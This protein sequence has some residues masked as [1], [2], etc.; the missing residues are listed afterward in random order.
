M[1][2]SA[3]ARHRRLASTTASRR[4]SAGCCTTPSRCWPTSSTPCD[5]A[6]VDKRTVHSGPRRCWSTGCAPS[7]SRASRSTS[8][9]ATSP[10]RKRTF[11]L[12]DTPGHVQYTRNTVTGA[13]HRGAGDPAGR[14]A[15]GRAW[16]RPAGTPP[17]LAL[18]RRA[19]RR[20]RGEQDRPGRLRRGRPSTVIAEGVRHARGRAR[21]P[22]GAV[23]PSRCPRC[24]GDNVVEHSANTPWYDGPTLL[25]HLETRA[26]RAGPARGAAAVPGAVRD[27]AAARAEY[28]DYRGYAGPVAAG[29]RAAGD[30]VVVLPG[31]GA[32]R[33][34]RIDTPDGPLPEATAGRSVTL[35]LADDIDISR[36]DLIVGE[37]EPPA[38]TDE[39]D[40]TLAW[41]ADKPLRAGARVL[42]KHGARTVQAIVSELRTRFDEQTTVHGGPSG[43]PGAER[44]RPGVAA[45][46]GAD[47]GRRL[48]QPRPDR[49]V[50]G[51]RPGRR[52][53][54]RGG[55]GRR[56]AAVAEHVDD[57]TTR[58]RRAR[59]PGP[60]VGGHDRRAGRRRARAGARAWTCARR[61][62]TCP[63]LGC[64]TCWPRC[65]AKA[66][67]T[68]WSCRCCWARHST[69]G[70]TCRRWSPRRPRGCRGSR[71]RWPTCSART[72]RLPD[73]ALRRLADAGRAAR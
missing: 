36:G 56:P 67:G 30:E 25:E 29:T 37:G 4:W 26:G 57:P 73:I 19:A 62:S 39:L 23:P 51:D 35:L 34:P 17:S 7:A 55:P 63:P 28:R 42:V 46:R 49:R 22:T 72:R 3:P 12:A 50:P 69:R 15:P 16:S 13:S 40:A 47:P 41:L 53:H 64:R 71:C 65:T 20:A 8:P 70:W 33:S 24:V 5:R 21:L 27:P 43:V 61:S 31:G 1:T 10:R 9:T 32:P 58:R 11:I 14:R 38:I 59:Q 52:R 48:R 54:A 18:L 60:A 6:S 44:D 2:D 68:S 45:Y 66:T